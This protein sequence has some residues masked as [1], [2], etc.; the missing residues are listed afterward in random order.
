MS[1]G[2]SDTYVI[3][4]CYL[5]VRRPPGPTRTATHF[6][7]TTLF[8]SPDGVTA[9]RIAEALV[10]APPLR[11]LQYRLKSLVDGQRLVMEGR[12]RWAIR[13]WRPTRRCCRD[14]KSTRLNSSN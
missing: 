6:P 7:Y 1:V 5:I 9:Q 2:D 10:S 12:G 4:L 8:R 11:T 14:R 3:Y 13:G